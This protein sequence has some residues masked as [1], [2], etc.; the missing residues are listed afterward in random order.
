MKALVAAL[1]AIAMNGSWAGL[2]S[3]PANLGPRMLAAQNIS[4]STGLATYTD[5]QK[6]LE[7]G[8]VV[9]EYVDAQGTVFAVSWSGPYLP[10][11]KEILGSHFDTL[12]AHAGNARRGGRSPLVLKQPDLM[13]VSGGHMGAFEGHAWLPAKLPAGFKPGNIK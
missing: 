8:T 13:I 3:T 10:D 7:S 9:H 5:V 6:K 1:L 2:G 11:L 4:G 12:V